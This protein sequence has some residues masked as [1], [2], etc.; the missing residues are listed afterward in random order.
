MEEYHKNIKQN[1]SIVS[2][3]DRSAR[4]QSNHLF[5]CLDFYIRQIRENQIV[6]VLKSFC[7]KVK[8]YET[9]LIIALCEL[10]LIIEN[11]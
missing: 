7:S 9:A 4:G 5:I 6:K 2:S 11:L 3:P 8:I 10:N 1:A